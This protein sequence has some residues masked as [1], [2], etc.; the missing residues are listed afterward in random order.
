MLMGH[1]SREHVHS[2]AHVEGKHWLGRSDWVSRGGVLAY[3]DIAEH[4]ERVGVPEVADLCEAAEVEEAAVWEKTKAK[5]FKQLQK[6][7]TRRWGIR[8]HN[9]LFFQLSAHQQY[10]LSDFGSQLGRAY[11]YCL[12]T[13]PSRTYTDEE[14]IL[15]IRL[16]LG[17][18]MDDYNPYGPGQRCQCRH[19]QGLPWNALHIISCIDV[20]TA[21]S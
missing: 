21:N 18:G 15:Q 13:L 10:V 11:L 9:C 8:A 5:Q 16:L 19:D 1:R 20:Y 17:V 14:M 4:Y 6:D 12:P 2:S 7:A 3:G